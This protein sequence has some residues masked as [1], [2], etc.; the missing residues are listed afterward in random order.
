[1]H[2]DF[3]TNHIRTKYRNLCDMRVPDSIGEEMRAIEVNPYA[4][5][6]VFIHPR[7]REAL[8]G[9]LYSTDIESGK[10][11]VAV[12]DTLYTIRRQQVELIQ[13]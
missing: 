9:I 12:G 13:Y 5:A 10:I 4:P 7:T 1:M 11:K 8:C 2:F 6:I 3:N